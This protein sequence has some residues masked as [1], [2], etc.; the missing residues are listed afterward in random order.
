VEAEGSHLV[1]GQGAQAAVDLVGGI[2]VLDHLVESLV[3]RA[4]RSSQAEAGHK[5][6][7]VH[8]RSLLAA[9]HILVQTDRWAD[10]SHRMEVVGDSREERKD[11]LEVGL[12]EE[13]LVVRRSRQVSHKSW[14]NK[15]Y[16]NLVFL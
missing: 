11:R 5:G 15:L 7:R 10:S 1:E 2:A 16:N 4:D 9:D 6:S 12:V 3:R 8:G 14:T 13:E